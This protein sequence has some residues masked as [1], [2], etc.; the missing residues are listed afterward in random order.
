MVFGPWAK[1]EYFV[2]YGRGFHSNDARGVTITVDPKSC[3]QPTG[4]QP[5]DAV[6]PLVRTV[7]YEAGLRT[8]I[9]PTVQ[10]SVALWRL[11]QDSELLFTGDAGTTVASRPSIRTGLEWEI[12][13]VPR[14]W[15]IVDLIYAKTRARFDDNDP[16]GIGTRI[17]GALETAA[18]AAISVH[19]LNGWFGSV[20]WRYF[21]PRPLI[22]DNSVRSQS[23]IETNL[24]IGKRIN[25]HWSATLDVF[26]LFNRVGSDVDYFYLSRIT[27][28]SPALN[29]I[30]FHPVDKRA[31]RLTLTGYF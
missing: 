21:G 20:D 3:A 1:T 2:N 10:S 15:L 19:N 8:Q 5:V 29:D 4:C 27:S 6:T 30:H 23:T 16:D 31:L 22:E 11:K 12:H 28:T 25:K 9:I 14:P 18:T 7:G 13:Y 24:K 17:P 26:N